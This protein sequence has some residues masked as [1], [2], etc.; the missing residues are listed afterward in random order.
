[1]SFSVFTRRVKEKVGLADRAE[2][3]SSIVD[4]AKR[5]NSLNLNL[6]KLIK[7]LEKS[8]TATNSARLTAQ[9]FAVSWQPCNCTDARS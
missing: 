1:M 8:T 4:E 9:L 7:S 2:E 3:N 5:V 6:K